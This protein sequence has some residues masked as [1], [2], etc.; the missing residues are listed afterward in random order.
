MIAELGTTRQAIYQGSQP[1]G[2]NR[3]QAF[4]HRQRHM[5]RVPEWRAVKKRTP[6]GPVSAFFS[7]WKPKAGTLRCREVLSF[8]SIRTG[9]DRLTSGF[10]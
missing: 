8:C 2:W 10:R 1:A 7:L 3:L 6:S 9:A 5:F 4:A